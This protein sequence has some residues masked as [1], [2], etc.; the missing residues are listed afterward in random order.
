MGCH[1]Y[2]FPSPH[3]W[4]SSDSCCCSSSPQGRE[5][6]A[7]CGRGMGEVTS[8]TRMQ[9][10]PSLEVGVLPGEE[11]PP[12]RQLRPLHSHLQPHQ[13]PQL[14]SQR[15][16]CWGQLHTLGQCCVLLPQQEAPVKSPVPTVAVPV[17]NLLVKKPPSCSQGH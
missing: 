12:D 9:T 4:E 5:A 6:P 10:L 17:L 8:G 3:T 2:C 14:G 7:G 15:P 11:T 1:G 13:P 16:S